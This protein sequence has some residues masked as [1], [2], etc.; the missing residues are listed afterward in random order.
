M[1][2][3]VLAWAVLV[4]LVAPVVAR[5]QKDDPPKPAGKIEA[6]PKDFDK[7]R[8]GIDHGKLETAEYE[9]KTVGTTR[10]VTMYTLPGYTKDNKYPVLY[11]LHG[12]GGDENEWRRGGRT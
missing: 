11:L 2:G 10:K 7:K 5:S 9:S 8:N 3:R 12:I 6:L 4:A 1:S